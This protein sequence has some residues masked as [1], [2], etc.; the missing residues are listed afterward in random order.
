M[1]KLFIT[2]A[3]VITGVASSAHADSALTLLGTV[4]TDTSLGLGRMAAIKAEFVKR[5]IEDF[6]DFGPSKTP[7]VEITFVE[8]FSETGSTPGEIKEKLL[9]K[10]YRFATAAEA[11]SLDAV[12]LLEGKQ[13]TCIGTMV[14]LTHEEFMLLGFRYHTGKAS[15]EKEGLEMLFMFTKH[16][17]WKGRIIVPAV[18]ITDQ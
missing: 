6:R 3:F 13:V 14:P 11:A 10:G 9:T 16:Q 1:K 18:K 8:H 4:K 5:G 15:T 12:P 2:L 17:G 7:Q